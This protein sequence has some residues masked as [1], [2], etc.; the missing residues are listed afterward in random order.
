MELI[1]EYLFLFIIYI[2][3]VSNTSALA[4]A[5]AGAALHVVACPARQF[6]VAYACLLTVSFCELAC[7]NGF[8]CPPK[9]HTSCS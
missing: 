6:A 3:D 8:Y 2:L 7:H 5:A 1:M 4:L 9:A